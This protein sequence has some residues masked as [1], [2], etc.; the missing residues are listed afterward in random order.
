MFRT[1][2]AENPDIWT[3]ELKHDIYEAFREIVRLEDNYLDFVFSLGDIKGLTKDE[4]KQYIRH[5]ADRRLLEFGMKPNFKVK[6]NPLPWMEEM[7]N[8]SS[9]SNFFDVTVT[10]YGKGTLE[11]TW[12]GAK[13]ILD[14]FKY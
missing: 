7:V 10:E 6:E 2:I 5:L 12:E 4:M 9:F 1:F 8:A 13:S 11:G 14:S 3:D